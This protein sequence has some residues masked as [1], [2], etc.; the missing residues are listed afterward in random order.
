[1][2]LGERALAYRIIINRL[3]GVLER[4]SPAEVAELTGDGFGNDAVGDEDCKEHM[5]D[6]VLS[7]LCARYPPL[8][9]G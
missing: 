3:Q 6:L 1:M 4:A 8:E 5:S 2:A 7:T 9:V